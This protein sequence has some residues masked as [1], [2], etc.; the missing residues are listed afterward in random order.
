MGNQSCLNVVIGKAPHLFHD[1]LAVENRL[2]IQ[3]L[4]LAPQPA[5]QNVLQSRQLCFPRHHA[6]DKRRRERARP[7]G[8]RLDDVLVQK[9]LR[10]VN[11]ASFENT[12]P[13]FFPVFQDEPHLCPVRDHLIKRAFE[14][15]LP[16]RD[17]TALGDF[18]QVIKHAFVQQLFQ[19]GVVIPLQG[20][21]H[22]VNHIGHFH[23]VPLL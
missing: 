15:P 1:L 18:L 5:V 17:V 9:N 10:L 4:A 2:Q 13:G 12:R 3:P 7:H 22:D 16:R 21:P 6:V 20:E 23:P 11:W 14:V 8:L 19:A